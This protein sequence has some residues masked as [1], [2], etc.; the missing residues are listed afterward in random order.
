MVSAKRWPDCVLNHCS[1]SEAEGFFNLVLS[2]LFSLYDAKTLD[3]KKIVEHLLKVVLTSSSPEHIHLKFRMWVV[4]D[5]SK[6]FA[7]IIF[8]VSE[9]FS[10]LYQERRRCVYLFARL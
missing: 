9:I 6:A 2:H 3:A 1:C 10:M 5:S 7:L 8:V 4:L